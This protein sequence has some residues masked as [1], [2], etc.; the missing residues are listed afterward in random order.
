VLLYASNR[1]LEGWGSLDVGGPVELVIWRSV[2]PLETAPMWVSPTQG[3]PWLPTGACT[4]VRGLYYLRAQAFRCLTLLPKLSTTLI[5]AS[6]ACLYVPPYPCFLSLPLP[7]YSLSSLPL[8]NPFLPRM[9]RHNYGFLSRPPPFPGFPSL[10][11]SNP[12][13]PILRLPSR[14]FPRSSPTTTT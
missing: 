5:L 7:Y 2:S 10:L 9:P 14:D 3:F 4:T 11:F 8:P 13:L 12:I 1:R 6:R